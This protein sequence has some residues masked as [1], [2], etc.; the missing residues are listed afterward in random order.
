VNARERFLNVLN[1]RPVD[2]GVY[3]MWVGWWPETQQRWQREG[4]D[5]RQGHG[6]PID[7]GFWQGGWFFPNPP[8][9]RDVVAEDAETVTYVNHEGILMRERKD[10]PYSSMPQ[11]VRFPV[12]T[13]ADFRRFWAERMRP[14][15]GARLGADYGAKLA[16]YRT[17][18]AP[19]IVVADRWGGFFGGPRNLTGVEKLC[20]LFYDDPAFV[21]EMMDTTA[22]FVIAMMDG[23]LAHTDVDVF[24]FWDDMAYKT[25]PLIGPEMV[26]RVMLPRYRRVVDHLR[27]KG[28]EWFSLDSDGDMSSLIPVWLDAGINILYPFEVQCGMDVVQVR[29]QYGRD[30]RLW[31][32]IDKRAVAQGPAAIEAELRRVRPLLDEGGYIAGL[33]HSLPPD[34]P[35]AHFRCFMERLW[36]LVNGRL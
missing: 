12:E 18:E 28:V 15:L 2:R 31:F 34:V 3:G 32:G 29:R 25:G 16:A 26:R 19:L 8:F 17:R 35:Y 21:E 13:R 23:I 22:D 24:G 9:A 4:Y 30:L 11:F 1:Y 36:N 27:A 14:D 5:P 33:D 7:P 10:N 20:T 6:F